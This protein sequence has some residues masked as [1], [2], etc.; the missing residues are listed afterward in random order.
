MSKL[1]TAAEM[2][3]AVKQMANFSAKQVANK[4]CLGRYNK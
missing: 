2:T 1:K 4:A 3:T